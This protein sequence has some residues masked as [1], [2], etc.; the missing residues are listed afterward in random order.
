MKKLN[1]SWAVLVR[2]KTGGSS[3]YYRKFDNNVY[4]ENLT[5]DRVLDVLMPYAP[6]DHVGRARGAENLVQLVLRS[7]LADSLRAYDDLNTYEKAELSFPEPGTIEV[8]GNP[9]H[10]NYQ[11]SNSNFG[12]LTVQGTATGGVVSY[13]PSS[14]NASDPDAGYV[15]LNGKS[16]DL[17]IFSSDPKFFYNFIEDPNGSFS[18]KVFGEPVTDYHKLLEDLES[19]K[20]SNIFNDADLKDIYNNEDNWVDRLASVVLLILKNLSK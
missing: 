18:F 10:V 9:I 11:P 1:K 16:N 14:S 8:Y 7:R 3:D 19:F 13:A 5:Y 20:V 4:K 6:D 2:E 17:P 15:V 12:C